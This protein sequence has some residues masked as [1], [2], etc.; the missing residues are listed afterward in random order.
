MIRRI[1]QN[2]ASPGQTGW[3]TPME[4]TGFVVLQGPKRGSPICNVAHSC[5]LLYHSLQY[6]TYHNGAPSKIRIVFCAMTMILVATCF[7]FSDAASDALA[8]HSGCRV[9]KK[10]RK[11]VTEAGYCADPRILICLICRG[12][13][14]RDMRR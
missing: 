3:P 14:R 6:N 8:L 10:K 4:L 13:G 1:T 12:R 2:G 7:F 9:G 11:H 5:Y